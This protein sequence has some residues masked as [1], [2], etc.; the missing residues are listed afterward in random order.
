MPRSRRFT[1]LDP[2]CLGIYELYH[3]MVVPPFFHI[4]M[5]ILLGATL[6]HISASRL[7]NCRASSAGAGRGLRLFLIPRFAELKR[8]APSQGFF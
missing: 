4:G 2:L 1:H 8:R 5:L 7:D 6:V 3:T